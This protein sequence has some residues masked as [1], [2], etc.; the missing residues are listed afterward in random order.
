MRIK[1][2]G[3]LFKDYALFDM[4]DV[5]YGKNRNVILP[6]QKNNVSS[7]L[8]K[9]A[10]IVG[11]DDREF[12]ISTR[13]VLKDEFAIS[14][15]V[16]HKNYVVQ[17]VVNKRNNKTTNLLDY[18]LGKKNFNVVK[19]KQVKDFLMANRIE[20]FE[21]DTSINTIGNITTDV[22]KSIINIICVNNKVRKRR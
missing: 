7:F 11:E 19:N 2:A 4:E 13:N 8:F 18:F 1:T 20:F 15:P 5:E 12:F 10:R 21:T 17:G 6:K 14:M 9:N 22:R 16:F 3:Y